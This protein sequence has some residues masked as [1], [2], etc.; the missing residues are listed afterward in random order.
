MGRRG[1]AP[2]PTSLKLLRGTKPSRVNL[3]EPKPL[4]GPVDRPAYL[5]AVAAQEWDRVAPHLEAMG[6]L[7]GADAT[8]L[9]VYCEAVARWRRTADLAAKSPPVYTRDGIAVR[10][11]LYSQARDAAAEVR[12]MARE[13]GLTPSARAGIRVD[14]H[15]SDGGRRLLTGG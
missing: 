7:T 1:P 12:L 13:F 8:A 11:P 4:P 9:A 3:R 15:V 2:Q 5:S 10:N 6:T 14:L